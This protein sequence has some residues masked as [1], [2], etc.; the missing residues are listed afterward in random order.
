MGS[1]MC[2]RDSPKADPKAQKTAGTSRVMELL[3]ELEKVRKDREAP[4]AAKDVKTNPE[5][6]KGIMER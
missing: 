3:K 6:D 5:G 4:D 2:I 1:E